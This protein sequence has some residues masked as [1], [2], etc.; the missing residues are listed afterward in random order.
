[1]KKK[2]LTNKFIMAL[3]ENK[4][5]SNS[6]LNIRRSINRAKRDPNDTGNFF[7]NKIKLIHPAGILD[8]IH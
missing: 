2:K 8:E 3:H 4:I 1:M 6:Q 7:H 5:D